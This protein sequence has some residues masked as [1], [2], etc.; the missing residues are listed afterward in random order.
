MSNGTNCENCMYYIYDEEFDCYECQV[1]L[2][3]DELARFL[4]ASIYHCPHFKFNDEYKIV[5]KQI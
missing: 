4:G 1:Y 3:E 2:D 5:R